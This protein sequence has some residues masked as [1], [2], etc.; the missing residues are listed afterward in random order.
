MNKSYSF[1]SLL[2][3]GVFELIVSS[4]AF[5]GTKSAYEKYSDRVDLREAAYCL[6]FL[7]EG[8]PLKERKSAID[9][10]Y[11]DAFEYNMTKKQ[12]AKKFANDNEMAKERLRSHLLDDTIHTFCTR[13][14]K[15]AW[16]LVREY[17]GIDYGSDPLARQPKSPAANTDEC[18]NA[19]DYEGCMRVKARGVNSLGSD[20]KPNEFCIATKGKDPLGFEKIEGWQMKYIPE[21]NAVIY[22]RSDPRK[23]LVRGKQDRYIETT[24]ILRQYRNPQAGT[25]GYSSNSTSIDTNC[26]SF[27]NDL[28]CTSTSTPGFSIQGRPADPGG[29]IQS[30]HVSVIDCEE[31]TIGRHLDGSIVGKW[32]KFSA[33]PDREAVQVADEFC[34][35]RTTLNLSTFTKYAD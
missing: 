27:G 24:A 18:L 34:P 25:R 12:F 5:A 13:R 6:D 20:C 21:G 17:T 16:E 19:R 2:A 23:V 11:V 26:Y 3:L 35:I 4:A 29:V 1:F 32:D 8:H 9:K 28:N 30:T 31:K 7:R 10:A 33:S 14:L 22:V 15:E